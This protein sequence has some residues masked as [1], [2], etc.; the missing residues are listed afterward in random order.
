[1]ID[2]QPHLNPIIVLVTVGVKITA[3]TQTVTIQ[4]QLLTVDFLS[5]V[6]TQAQLLTLLQ[7]FPPPPSSCCDH[8]QEKDDLYPILII[9]QHVS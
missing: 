6:A 7:F 9:K 5:T 2:R 8:G 3:I 1:M 4:A